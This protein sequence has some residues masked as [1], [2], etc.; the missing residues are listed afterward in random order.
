MI[1]VDT[2]VLVYAH[3]EDAKFHAEANA[4]LVKL[5]AGTERWAVPWPCAHEFIAIVTHPKIY[6]TPTP[7]ERA[8][9]ALAVLN[10]CPTL[11]FISEAEGY[12]DSLSGIALAARVQGGV[13]H[14]ARIVAICR[15]HGVRELWSADR[16]F[17]RFAG[18]KVRN[19]CLT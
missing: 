2:N 16:D 12:L 6:K 5:A 17:S 10:A 3:R 14:D 4:A 18:L 11:E 13:I 7:L 15:F 1:A 9:E 8:L 19:P